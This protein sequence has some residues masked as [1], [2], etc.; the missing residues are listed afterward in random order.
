MEVLSPKSTN[1]AD[2]IEEC[3][4]GAFEGIV[5]ALRTFPSVSITGRIDEE[6]V[7]YLPTSIKFLCHIGLVTA[8]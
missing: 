7:S 2:F 1:R 4:S 6:L 3:K 8:P 5:A